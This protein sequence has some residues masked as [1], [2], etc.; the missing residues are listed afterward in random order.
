MQ[1]LVPL[2]GIYEFLPKHKN[3]LSRNLPQNDY[4]LKG[5]NE[6]R[7]FG[8]FNANAIIATTFGNG[9]IPKIHATIAAPV[10]ETCSRDYVSVTR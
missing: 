4:S 5:N 6:S 7:I 9:I 8:I 10:R 1:Y 3:I 2:F